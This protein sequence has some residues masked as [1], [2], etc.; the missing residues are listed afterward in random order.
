MK[1]IITR[2]SDDDYIEIK[3]FASIQSLID[4]M[5]EVQDK[6]IIKNN[7]WHEEDTTYLKKWYPHLD[8]DEIVNIPYE[9]EIYDDYRE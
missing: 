7:F 6:L 4:F 1:F 3:E 8:V 5:N 9:I 2:T